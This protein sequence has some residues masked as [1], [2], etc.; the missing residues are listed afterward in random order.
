MRRLTF[1]TLALLALAAFF[2]GTATTAAAQQQDAALGELRRSAPDLGLT[3]ADVSSVEVTSSYTSRHN[4]VTHVYVRQQHE[5]LPVF[6]AVGGVHLLPSGEVLSMDARFVRDLARKAPSANP[7]LAA[8]GAIRSAARALDLGGDAT[9]T[10]EV[11]QDGER[12]ALFD[13]GLVSRDPIPTELGYWLRDDGTVA[14]AWKLVIH[15]WNEDADWWE[16]AIDAASGQVLKQHN[17]VVKHHWHSLRK[18]VPASQAF[19]RH[20]Q[21]AREPQSGTLAHARATGSYRVFPLPV[22]SPNHGTRA[23]VSGADLADPL[24]SPFGWHDTDGA[25]GAEH[26]IT[27]GNNVYAYEDRADSNAPG[28][29]PDGGADL[30]FDFPLD[31]ERSPV[32]SEDA[33]IT[34][35]FYWS[36]VIH[37]VLY[38]YG[39][40]EQAGNFQ[41]NNYGRGPTGGDGDALNAEAQDGSGTNNANFATPPDGNPPRMQMYLWSPP[42][43]VRL[44]VNSPSAIAREEVIAGA[45]FGRQWPSDGLTENVV[46]ALDAGIDGGSTPQ[47]GCQEIINPEEVSGS[48]A[49]IDRGNCPFID[50][51]RNAQAAGAVGVLVANNAPGASFTMG[52]TDPFVTIPSGMISRSTGFAIRTQVTSLGATVNVTVRDEF[53]GAPEADSAIDNGIIAHEYGHGVHT[54]LTGGPGNSACFRTDEQA[55]EG[56]ADFFALAFTQQTGGSGETRRGIGTYAIGEDVDGR[57]IRFDPYS[58]DETINA[59]TYDPIKSARLTAEND[60]IP[61]DVGQVWAM[62]LWEMYWELVDEHGFDPD[63]YNGT[64]GNNIAI[65]LVMDGLKLQPCNPGFVDARDAILAADRASFDGANSCSIWRAFAKRGLGV[66]ADQGTSEEHEDGTEDFTLPAACSA[67]TSSEGAEGAAA[68]GLERNYPNPFAGTTQITFSLDRTA[69]AHLAVYDLMGREV[70]TLVDGVLSAGEHEAEF[71]ASGL[72]AGVYLYR[73]EAGGQTASHRLVVMK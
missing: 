16:M 13:G 2:A 35:M 33:I 12:I 48:I 70:A 55:G 30:V 14:L 56:W 7:S 51:V 72:A 15:E 60:V 47:D 5:G 44:S 62:M 18:H 40:D 22:E 67:I 4:G 32:A 52:G 26:T 41:E 42:S 9:M 20:W 21:Q 37:D 68:F 31:Q 6:N 23:L 71:D 17:Y 57:G 11:E 49:L 1:P 45:A 36:N 39:F 28:H 69:P 34:N 63:L 65:Q 58:T 61:H 53:E 43:L 29:S 3:R 64:G 66:N 8:D 27:R 54:R 59:F 46:A 73:L 25:V 10:L 24:A 19:A 38:H 50:K